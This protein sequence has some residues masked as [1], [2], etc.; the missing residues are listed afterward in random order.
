MVE[1]IL[2][3]LIIIIMQSVLD[4]FFDNQMSNADKSGQSF[5]SRWSILYNILYELIA[6]YIN[7][8]KF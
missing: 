1:K 8:W 6:L 5:E 7:Y 3:I 4:I 2:F